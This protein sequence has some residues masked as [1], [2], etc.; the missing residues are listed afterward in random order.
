[1]TKNDVPTEV[2]LDRTVQQLEHAEE[3]ISILFNA[4][5]LTQDNARMVAFVTDLRVQ[6]NPSKANEY[7]NS[8][9]PE[10]KRAIDKKLWP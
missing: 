1:M 6:V 2:L 10:I 7:F 4:L 5:K 9:F 8:I 3:H